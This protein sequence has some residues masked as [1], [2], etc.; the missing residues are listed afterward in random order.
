MNYPVHL[1]V[2]A[3]FETG[4]SRVQAE[5][6]ALGETVMVD[7]DLGEGSFASTAELPGHPR[8]FGIR[9]FC[10]DEAQTLLCHDGVVFTESPQGQ[11]LLFLLEPTPGAVAAR[12]IGADGH[13]GT[14][15]QLLGGLAVLGI[16][17]VWA[18]R[19]SVSRG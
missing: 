17:G 3:G 15:I 8:Y 13:M 4:V 18:V 14:E 1:V 10:G 6:R 16:L 7:L 2:E 19:R 12:R 9:L 5:I 11:N